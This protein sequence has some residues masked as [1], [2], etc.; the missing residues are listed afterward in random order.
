M[1]EPPVAGCEEEYKERLRRLFVTIIIDFPAEDAAH[2]ILLLRDFPQHTT[3]AV[4]PPKEQERPESTP[5]KKRAVRLV[6]PLPDPSSGQRQLTPFDFYSVEESV[7]LLG[8]SKQT[9][10]NRL[11]DDP[12]SLPHKREPIGNGKDRIW[13]K[14]S[15]IISMRLKREKALKGGAS[16][17]PPEE[18]TDREDGGPE[19][20]Y[21]EA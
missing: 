19:D 20:E 7:V 3:A 16:T 8:L 12:E 4:E 14:G 11:R 15:G 6:P 13:L 10:Y 5:A 2:M 1:N 9:I 17:P 18:N 21:E